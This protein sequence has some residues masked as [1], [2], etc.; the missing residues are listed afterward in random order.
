MADPRLRILLLDAIHFRRMGI[1]KSLSALGYSRVAPLASLRELLVV[2]DNALCVFDLLIIN[3]SVLSHA[4]AVIEH[5]IRNCPAIKHLL[6]YQ[7][8][9]RLALPATESS[10]VVT[11]FTLPYPPDPESIRRIMGLIDKTRLDDVAW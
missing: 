1:E 3:A 7:D 8:S 2:M 6:V 11:V 9:E 10:T 4:G 5:S